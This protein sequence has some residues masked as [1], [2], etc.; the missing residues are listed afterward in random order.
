MDRWALAGA[1]TLLAVSLSAQEPPAA[2]VV[3]HSPDGRLQASFGPATPGTVAPWRYRLDRVGGGRPVELLGWSPLGVVRDDASL[4]ELQL[5]DAGR[6]ATV[7]D[8]YT[9][10]H[11]K[12]RH[13]EHIAV[14]RRIALT[15]AAGQPLTI[16]AR[17]AD[18]GL[19]F[20][21]AFPDDAPSPR[22]V[23]EERT[24]F[25]VPA[26]SRGWLLPHDPPGR[27]APA[28][29][30]FFSE[31]TAGTSAPSPEGWSYPVLFEI[32]SAGASGQ[33]EWLL[34]T[35]AAVDGAYAGTRLAAEA[36][37]GVYRVRLP[38]QGEG[39]GQGE[40][41]PRHAG[42][43]TLPWRVVVAGSLATIFQSTLVDD[44]NPPA[45]G[46]FSWVR[47]GRASIGWWTDDEA[48][49]KEEVLKAF[50]DL[51]ASMGWEHSL[52]DANWHLAP[53]G[54]LDRVVAHAREKGVGLWLW[55]NSGG[56]HNDVTEWGPRE[57]IFRAEVRRAE[58]A[59]IKAL[60]IVGVKVDFWHSDK[61]SIMALYHD[62]LCDAAA[63]G[64][65]VNLHGATTPR[66]WSRSYPNLLSVEAVLGAEQ[67]KY[68]DRYAAGAAAHNTVLPFTR[69]VI[70]PMDYL[71]VAIADAA[72]PRQTTTA[73]ELALSVVF[74][75]GVQHFPDA[76]STYATLPPTAIDLLK[77]V[78]VAWDESRLLD[79][80][81]GR[82]AVVA[83]RD[84]RTWWVG[85]VSGASEA[86][87]VAL[88]L[89]FL[90]SGEWALTMARDGGA[91]RHV[92]S[93][94]ATVRAVD[95]FSVPVL[96]RGG[97]LMRFVQP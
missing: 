17:V 71:P 9:M 24:G 73:H 14:E 75:S 2:P 37:G 49:K 81:P 78:P 63:A 25:A 79:G 60:G 55:Y 89:S 93:E 67:Y 46:D 10:P 8:A 66:G 70:G 83:R 3:V 58:F 96:P 4:I 57:R 11:G 39:L 61:P 32:A 72:H 43:W 26:G 51:S 7:R 47:P 44:L 22:R 95:R 33:P 36:P 88:D 18:D 23:R 35:E 48:S 64:L 90:G 82:L 94:A 28:Y 65:L 6:P 29:E 52:V 1:S 97:F 16:V 38:S 34:V 19:A 85:A 13:R 80:A 30:G 69:N 54:A 86:A 42:P 27:W 74:E 15:T 92:L 45:E 62:V 87:T 56:P 84:G 12:R 91:P 68:S 21:Y 76:P 77:T 40:V 31:V 59:R 20:R 5:L 41:E 50:V 53:D